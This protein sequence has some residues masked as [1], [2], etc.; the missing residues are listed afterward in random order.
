MTSVAREGGPDDVATVL[1]VVL[2]HFIASFGYVGWAVQ[3]AP[4][5]ACEASA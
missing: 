1:P 5:T 3:P 4:D 2:D